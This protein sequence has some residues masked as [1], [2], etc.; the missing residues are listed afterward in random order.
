MQYVREYS[1]YIVFLV[2]V[3][4]YLA[5]DFKI[6]RASVPEAFLSMQPTI[7]PD[8]GIWVWEVGPMSTMERGVTKVQF[9]Y[10]MLVEGDEEEKVKPVYTYARVIALEGDLV[11]TEAGKVLVNGK[12]V[13]VAVVEAGEKA[14]FTEEFMVP[15]GHIY[16]LSDMRRGRI[17]YNVDSRV[18]GPIPFSLVTGVV[19]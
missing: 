16:V 14:D 18:L 6:D 9:R 4:V 7:K 12:P 3:W 1:N 8:S 15:R 19:K 10:Q 2:V 13:Q 11:K 5:V 17:S